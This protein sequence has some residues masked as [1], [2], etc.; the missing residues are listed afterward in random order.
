MTNTNKNRVATADILRMLAD[1]VEKY[2]V[3]E[4]AEILEGNRKTAFASKPPFKDK[5]KRGK[6]LKKNK[7]NERPSS[8]NDNAKLAEELTQLT[9]REAGE[10]LLQ[11]RVAN[12]IVLEGLARFLQL[13]VQRDDTIAKL[14]SKITEN[15]I[16]SRL[17]SD[18]IQGKDSK[19]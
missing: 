13:P 11:E 10:L 19:N 3:E 2:S 18:A 12:K 1:F 16:G 17:R 7:W 9:S 8:T 15:T 5:A 14:R 4:L 6:G